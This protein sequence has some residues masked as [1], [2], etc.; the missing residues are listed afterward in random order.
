MGDPHYV[1]FDGLVH[2][3]QGKYTY[4]V[5]QTIPDLHDTLTPFS[6]EGTNYPLHRNSRI[7]YLKE[8]LINVYNH[9][10]RFR[11]DKQI[12]VSLLL[13]AKHKGSLLE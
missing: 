3:F 2:H 11:E 5:A 10:V 7:T 8:I 9:K 12:L 4:I 1:T 13:T 6:I